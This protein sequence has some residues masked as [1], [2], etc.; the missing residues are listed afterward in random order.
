MGVVAMPASGSSR[1]MEGRETTDTPVTRATQ[2][3][4]RPS[5]E[6]CLE[7]AHWAIECCI[8]WLQS[9]HPPPSE[10][11]Q[12]LASTSVGGWREGRVGGRQQGQHQQG[13]G[14]GAP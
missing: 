11:G 9:A 14:G 5:A 3:P 10:P 2:L 13:G 8:G 12:Q 7:F 4:L 1:R 6:C